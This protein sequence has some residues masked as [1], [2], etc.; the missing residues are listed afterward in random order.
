MLHRST[1]FKNSEM[2]EENVV[3]NWHALTI[4]EFECADPHFQT[5]EGNFI[6][7]RGKE[8]PVRRGRRQSQSL[9]GNSRWTLNIFFNPQGLGTRKPCFRRPVFL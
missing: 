3:E 2:Q 5:L 8:P 9:H 1:F 6:R 7:N 4:Y